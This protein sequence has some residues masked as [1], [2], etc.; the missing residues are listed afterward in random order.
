[1][2]VAVLFAVIGVLLGAVIGLFLGKGM[3]STSSTASSSVTA[4]QLTQEQMNA[5]QLPP[6]HPK[7]GGLPSA[8]ATPTSKSKKK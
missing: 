3:V 5:G 1:M 7:I 4:P 2:T 8:A 6:G